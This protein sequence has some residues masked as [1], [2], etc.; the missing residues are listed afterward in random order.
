MGRGYGEKHGHGTGLCNVSGDNEIPELEK[1]QVAAFP[2]Q[3][4]G[5]PYISQPALQ[6]SEYGA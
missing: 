6:N 4:P 3:R 5:W 1:S 2:C